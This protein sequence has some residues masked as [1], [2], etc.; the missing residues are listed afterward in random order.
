MDFTIKHFFKKAAKRAQDR[1]PTMHLEIRT[2]EEL[3]LPKTT[4]AQ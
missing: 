4:S 3:V 1:R 2:H